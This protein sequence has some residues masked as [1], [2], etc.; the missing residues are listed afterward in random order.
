MWVGIRFFLGLVVVT[1]AA[2]YS[3]S[4]TI[5]LR[6]KA[7][8]KPLRKALASREPLTGRRSLQLRE[9]TRTG[10]I[11]SRDRSGALCASAPDGRCIKSAAGFRDPDA[12]VNC[13]SPHCEGIDFELTVAPVTGLEIRL[14]FDAGRVSGKVDRHPPARKGALPMTRL[15]VLLPDEYGVGPCV[16]MFGA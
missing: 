15:V 9:A 11:C 8:L 13:D 7:E 4:G 12:L 10:A 6:D 3:V 16:E 1:A 5:Y 14:S 2:G